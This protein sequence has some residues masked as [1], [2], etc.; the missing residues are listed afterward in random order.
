MEAHP[1][2]TKAN[3]IAQG[4]QKRDHLSGR[5]IHD[6]STTDPAN[7]GYKGKQWGQQQYGPEMRQYQARRRHRWQ[8][9]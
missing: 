1:T 2:N 9:Q 7:G 5:H 8:H 6:M 4:Q 3:H